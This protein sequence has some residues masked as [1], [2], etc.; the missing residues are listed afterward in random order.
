MPS[1]FAPLT[2]IGLLVVLALA[3]IVPP[4]AAGAASRTA[5]RVR[6]TKEVIARFA[7]VRAPGGASVP[8]V[9]TG[10]D[11]SIATHR[12]PGVRGPDGV[13][14]RWVEWR[15][16]RL[17]LH[18]VALSHTRERPRGRVAPTRVD[19]VHVRP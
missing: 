3:A 12:I 18:G 17:G 10:R 4:G 6:H 7:D 2:T 9:I 8:P 15:V 19:N 16:D 11:V 5:T 14:H 13:E 1:P